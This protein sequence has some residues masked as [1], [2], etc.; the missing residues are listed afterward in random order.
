MWT[1]FLSLIRGIPPNRATRSGLPSRWT[2]ASKQVRS[3]C[4]VS[5][6]AWYLA[7]IRHGGL[8]LRSQRFQHRR[9]G[10]PSQSVETPDVDGESVVADDATVFGRIG[11]DD[12][13]V[14]QVLQGRPV[15]GFAVAPVGGTLALITSSGTRSAMPPLIDRRP[16]VSLSS[17][18]WMV[19]S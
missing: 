11:L 14:V 3:P 9:Q 4:A 16:C 18:C 2:L 1:A 12:V 8:V 6:F 10:V 13:V 17:P 15:P 19:I 7:A 5:I